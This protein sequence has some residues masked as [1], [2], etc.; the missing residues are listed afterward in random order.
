MTEKLA[1]KSGINRAV[2]SEVHRRRKDHQP[3][4]AAHLETVNREYEKCKGQSKTNRSSGSFFLLAEA[5]S[6][7]SVSW[8]PREE[9]FLGA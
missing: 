8:F 6:H 9:L 2:D 5:I 1:N 7:I 4:N 3:L